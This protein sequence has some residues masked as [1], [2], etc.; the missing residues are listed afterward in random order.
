[1]RTFSLASIAVVLIASIATY[2]RYENFD[3]CDWMAQDLASQ[4]G[5]PRLVVNA[6]IQSQFLIRG[7]VDP[8]IGQCIVAW[9]DFRV[10]G[11]PDDS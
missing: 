3:P 2:V 8:D 10:D 4:S 1:M 6:R 7:I 5:L 11:L 9:W